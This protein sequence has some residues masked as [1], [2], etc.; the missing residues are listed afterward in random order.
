M[1][2]WKC[3]QRP[4]KISGPKTYLQHMRLIITLLAALLASV[5]LWGQGTVIARVMDAETGSPLP[6]ATVLLKG[7]SR[8]TITNSEGWFSLPLQG[9]Q[10]SL[11][12]S[13]IG[14]RTRVISFTPSLDGSHILLERAV[15]ELGE[16]VIRPG[17]DLY[18]RVVAASNWLRR[19]PEVQAK[20]FYGLETHS[21]GQ[22]VEILNSYYSSTFKGA[23][24]TKLDFKRGRIG[25]APKDDRYFINFNTARAFALLDIH[26][27]Y[28]R[29]PLSPFSYTT[30]KT[31]KA[32]FLAEL[33]TAAGDAEGVDHIRVT[34]RD[35][36]KGAWVLDLWLPPGETTVRGLELSCTNCANYSFVPL[37]DHGRIDTVDMRYRQTWTTSPPLLPQVMELEY[38]TAY[39]G[40]GFS[41]R[42]RSHAIMHAF[43][44]GTPFIPTQFRWHPNL[45]EYRKIAWLPDDSI[46]WS[47]MTPPLPTERQMRDQAFIAQHDL[48]RNSW[49]DSLGTYYDLLRPVYKAW[50]KEKRLRFWEVTG[51]WSPKHHQPPDPNRIELHAQ[52]YLEMD[53]TNGAF[54]WFSCAVFAPHH[55]VYMAPL[56]IWSEVFIRIYFDL[57]EVERRKMD[58]RL[59]R[60]GMNV[61]RAE[62]IYREHSRELRNTLDKYMKHTRNGKDGL[63]LIP[64]HE[65]I[66]K[67]LNIHNL[68][69]E[70]WPIE[71]V[72]DRPAVFPEK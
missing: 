19:I 38:T 7:T 9:A 44:H 10:D 67:E 3:G 15:H 53:T 35:H 39:T 41:E 23:M 66:V 20:L 17:E 68:T 45:E 5:T 62:K 55:S 18:A 37:F 29:F 31:L 27:K 12:I 22:P 16:A 25:I 50:S 4:V 40:P 13:F 48:R 57:C 60:P 61:D 54:H 56:E 69:L 51:T 58:A 28:G 14:H 46:F 47:R 24:L 71:H 6:Y 32:D 36:V 26:Q 70:L 8:G 72:L 34:P 11:Q 30:R 64:W 65:V 21:D 63:S 52:L 43:D 33:V 2:G 59:D 42:F 49:Y 1:I